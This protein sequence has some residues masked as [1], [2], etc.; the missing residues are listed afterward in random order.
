M[1]NSTYRQINMS[2]E[3]ILGIEYW[4]FMIFLLLLWKL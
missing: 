4:L 3:D 1:Y 2:D